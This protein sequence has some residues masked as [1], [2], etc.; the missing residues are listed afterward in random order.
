MDNL[1]ESVAKINQLRSKGIQIFLD[2]FGTGYSSLKYLKNLPIDKLK[3]D[4][5]FIDDI[6]KQK[7]NITET[8]VA[9]AHKMG[10]K[11]VAE[12][13]EQKEQFEL[14]QEYACD[15]IQGYYISKPVFEDKILQ[16]IKD[17]DE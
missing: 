3:I 8:V 16:M 14:L 9:L 7:D 12:G 5:T 6:V 10:M 1:E 17:N 11:V 2:D 13:V 4:K 15:M